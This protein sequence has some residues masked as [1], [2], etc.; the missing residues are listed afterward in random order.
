MEVLELVARGYTNPQ[1]AE[2]LGI[3]L[4]GAKWHVREI[5]AKLGASSREEAAE[6]WRAQNRAG[7]RLTRTLHGLSAPV[8][9][10]SLAVGA[11]FAVGA[12]G[13]ILAVAALRGGD[14]SPDPVAPETPAITPTAG[15]TQTAV[16]SVTGSPTPVPAGTVSGLFDDPRPLPV[17]ARE[18]A[19]PGREFPQ[20]LPPPTFDWDGE[21]TMV[22]DRQ[23]GTL[24]DLGPGEP[25]AFSP[26]GEWMAWV[27]EDRFTG[28][29]HALNLRTGERR[30]L[31]AGGY[32]ATFVDDQRVLVDEQATEGILV[33]VVTG[34][35]EA[36]RDRPSLFEGFA[37]WLQITHPSETRPRLVRVSDLAG[38]RAV[39]FEAQSAVQIG[40]DE[41]IVV[42]VTQN[43]LS[44][45]FTVDFRSGSAT[46]IATTPVSERG[47]ALGGNG[48]HIAWSDL[49]ADPG[50]AWVF[51]RQTKEFTYV[52]K[53]LMVSVGA[54]N[55]LLGTGFTGIERLIDPDTMEYIFISPAGWPHWSQD[56]RY[57]SV[58]QV[59]GHG[60][61]CGP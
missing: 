21:S 29:L 23:T 10:K 13:V 35:R 39:E 45:I 31:G 17:A 5:I 26:S 53:G 18:L 41:L 34:E 50:E 11:L 51:E 52:P 20:S 42:T 43:G 30:D 32:V 60:G 3:T 25:G 58:G 49:C 12:S 40:T 61:I 56:F 36:V 54:P 15:P 59:G 24:I 44:N 27:S 46:Y 47:F 1:I 9:L 8:A 6:Q 14:S 28:T 22:F 55:G 38:R 16:P 48:T 33:N 2:R 19:P 7:V 4:D 57:V 37:D